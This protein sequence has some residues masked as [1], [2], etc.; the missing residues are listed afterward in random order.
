MRRVLVLLAVVLLG[1]ASTMA[2]VRAVS[3]GHLDGNRHP[4]VACLLGRLPDGTFVGCGS[5]VLI[6]P[7]VVLVAAHEFLVLGSLGA[8]R[9]FVSFDA[10]VDTETSELIA[11]ESIV[12]DPSFNPTSWSGQDLAVLLLPSPV[13]GVSPVR[14]PTEGLLDD[15][16][17]GKDLDDQRFVVVGYGLDCSDVRPAMCVPAFDRT[18]R[19][20][21]EEVIS[22]QP[23]GF[24]VQTNHLATGEGGPCFG[25]SG[26][27][28]FLGNS[29]MVVGATRGIFGACRNAEFVTR[30]DT[31]GAR[32]FLADFVA[33]P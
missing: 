18:R 16:E 19:F 15:I 6:A 10:R 32:S 33:L 13:Q 29:N 11:P 22:L 21:T 31:P 8:T 2:P 20:A 12:S 28:H 17:Q 7:T 14:L 5:G 26:S 9:Y 24:T 4:S 30:L 27:P 1:E 23:T 25:D 3:N